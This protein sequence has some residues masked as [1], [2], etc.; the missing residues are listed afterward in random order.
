ML[1]CAW[2]EPPDER[3]AAT[4][5][6][7]LLSR[8]RARRARARWHRA[9]IRLGCTTHSGGDCVPNLVSVNGRVTRL[10]RGRVAVLDR[11]FLLADGIYEVMRTYG[12]RVF[13]L[14]AHLQR[15]FASLHGARIEPP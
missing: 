8:S 10:E 1:S 15:L 11:G 12:G 14:D 3:R 9:R 7:A 2:V 13:L 4:P 6:E 5:Q